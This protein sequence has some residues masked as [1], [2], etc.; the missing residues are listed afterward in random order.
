MADW[1]AFP[2]GIKDRRMAVLGKH[3]NLVVR[4]QADGSIDERTQTVLRVT[5]IGEQGLK[6]N[7]FSGY[8]FGSS[9]VPG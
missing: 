1:T 2:F 9:S 4:E 3:Q 8:S 6:R 7:G 5:R